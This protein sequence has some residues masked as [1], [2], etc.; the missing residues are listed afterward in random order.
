MPDGFRPDDP[1]TA[2]HYTFRV[3][4]NTANVMELTM[5]PKVG[6]GLAQRIVADRQA[7]GTYKVPVDLLRV[8][9]IGPKTLVGM[10]PYLALP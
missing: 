1:A 10:Q 7:R 9:G 6:P 2:R 8:R 3:D 4:P 5:L